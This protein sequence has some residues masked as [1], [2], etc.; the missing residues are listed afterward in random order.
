[1][2]QIA[3]EEIYREIFGEDRV[4]GGKG[5][6]RRKVREEIEVEKGICFLEGR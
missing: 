4:E 6:N 2:D 1:V 3:R 5:V